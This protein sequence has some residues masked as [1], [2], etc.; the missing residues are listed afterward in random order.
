MSTH[1]N[2]ESFDLKIRSILLRIFCLWMTA[3]SFQVANAQTIQLGATFRDLVANKPTPA[4][5]WDTQNSFIT[6]RSVKVQSLKCGAT[7]GNRLTLGMGYHW[8]Q[9][10]IKQSVLGYSDQLPMKMRY[11]SLFGE[12]VFYNKGNWEGII[13]VQLGY[14]HSFL[15]TQPLNNKPEKLYRESVILYEPN[16][17]IEY[18][19]S[20]WIGIGA[21][22]GYRIMLKNNPNINQNFYAPLYVFRA[23]ILFGEL[24]SRYGHLF[25]DEIE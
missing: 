25:Q 16:I 17:T 13:P 4:F 9:S 5:K 1:I 8:L 18:K 12:F 11:F 19:F 21:G 2:I 10:D 7:W 6:G 14:G 20:P 23:R 24:Y 22:Y 3:S 15:Q